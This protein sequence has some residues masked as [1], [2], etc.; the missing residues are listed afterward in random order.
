MENKTLRKL[1]DGWYDS[2]NR[3]WVLLSETFPGNT[4]QKPKEKSKVDLKESGSARESL[5]EQFKQTFLREGKTK[6]QAS[7]MAERAV[8][9]LPSDSKGDVQTRLKESYRRMFIQD[10]HSARVA[11]DMAAKAAGADL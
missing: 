2:N 10:G 5:R 11:E 3:K 7:E 4:N 8:Q 9:D 1:D 6:E